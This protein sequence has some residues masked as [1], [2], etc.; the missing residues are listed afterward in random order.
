MVKVLK[1]LA[2]FVEHILNRD[3][4]LLHYSFIDVSYYLLNNFEL[5]E[6]F[7]ASFQDILGENVLL[8]VD[9]EVRESFLGGIKNLGKV[10]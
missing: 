9:P 8:S 6:K 7:S 3:I 4:D 5:L 10:T 2:H 1:V